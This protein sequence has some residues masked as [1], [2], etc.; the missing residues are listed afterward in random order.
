MN[1]I[2]IYCD[3]GARGNGT[4]SVKCYGSFAV[5]YKGEIRKR[6]KQDFPSAKTNNQAEYKALGMVID[7]LYELQ[8]RKPNL[9]AIVIKMD[10]ALVVNQVNDV[11]KVK[12]DA[13]YAIHDA[14]Q[15]A[16]YLDLKGLDIKLV[17]APRAEIF[18]V[19]GH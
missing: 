13:L 15:H 12:N 17:Q 8:N 16:M 10:S 4:A 9:P 6:D 1:E 5:E 3:G 18:K 19:L 2:T 7:Y 14:I 11:W